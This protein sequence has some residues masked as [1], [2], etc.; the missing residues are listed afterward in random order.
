LGEKNGIQHVKQYRTISL[1]MLFSG[2][3]EGPGL[4]WSS[5]RKIGPLDKSDK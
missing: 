5:F 3:L 2:R 1:R 4:T